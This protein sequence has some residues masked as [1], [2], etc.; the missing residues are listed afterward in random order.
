[1]TAHTFPQDLVTACEAQVDRGA[2]E[3]KRAEW[4][5][6]SVASLGHNL[7]ALYDKLKLGK[8]NYRR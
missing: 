4:V 6:G 7:F 1:M 2:W 5:R 8:R 3:V